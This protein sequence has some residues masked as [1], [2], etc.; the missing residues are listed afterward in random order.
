MVEAGRNVRPETGTVEMCSKASRGKNVQIK[1]DWP[2]ASRQ[3]SGSEESGPPM[4]QTTAC[5]IS[6]NLWSAH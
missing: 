5:R 2:N 4:F 6:L 3:T 1:Y